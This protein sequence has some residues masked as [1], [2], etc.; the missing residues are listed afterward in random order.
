MGP[1]SWLLAAYRGG[2]SGVYAEF[3]AQDGSLH[4]FAMEAI[5][6]VFYYCFCRRLYV[7]GAVIP[8]NCFVEFVLVAGWVVLD[9]VVSF[10]DFVF[11]S[12]DNSS[13]FLK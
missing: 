11:L 2:C 6:E 12:E 13:F 9:D 3:I 10:W 7:F 4:S 5:P 1:V 8:L